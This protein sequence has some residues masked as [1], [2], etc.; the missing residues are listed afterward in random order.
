MTIEMI[1]PTDGGVL[2]T[3]V[4]CVHGARVCPY[5]GP[6]TSQRCGVSQTPKGWYCTRDYGHSGSCSAL[7]EMKIDEHPAVAELAKFKEGVDAVV[8]MITR[9]WI[10]EERRADDLEKQLAET[11]GIAE[12]A[13]DRAQRLMDE[14]DGTVGE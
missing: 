7:P 4:E 1:D 2:V 5:C 10:A 3:Q 14:R 11:K 9:N 12:R 13:L 8:L 6:K